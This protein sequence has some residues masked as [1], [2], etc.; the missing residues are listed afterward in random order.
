MAMNLANTD[1]PNP[2]IVRATC[3]QDVNDRRDVITRL[4]WHED[5]DLPEVRDIMEFQ[6]RFKATER[7]YK[8]AFKR[9][10]LQ[11]NAAGPDMKHMVRIRKRRLEEDGKDTQFSL[12]KRRVPGEKIDRWVQRTGFENRMTMSELPLMGKTPPNIDY[13]TPSEYNSLPG[14]P[15]D[16]EQDALVLASPHTHTAF[17]LG[18][19]AVLDLSGSP[20]P[21]TPRPMS[22]NSYPLS[23]GLSLLQSS[24]YDGEAIPP[25]MDEEQV[26][27]HR[28]N[29]SPFRLEFSLKEDH[30]DTI[31]SSV[32]LRMT[33]MSEQSFMGPT[34]SG[35]VQH[36]TLHSAPAL[37]PRHK[38]RPETQTQV[39]ESNFSGHEDGHGSSEANSSE[40]Q[41]EAYIR[42]SSPG[43]LDA[44]HSS[45]VHRLQPAEDDSLVVIDKALFEQSVL[46]SAMCRLAMESDGEMMGRYL[47]AAASRGDRV[48]VQEILASRHHCV[49]ALSPAGRTALSNAAFAGHCKIVKD[50]LSAGADMHVWLDHRG[51]DLGT[52]IKLAIEA[53]QVD[54]VDAI[55]SFLIEQRR[56][57]RLPLTHV[58]AVNYAMQ[59]ERLE[60]LKTLIRRLS[61]QKDLLWDSA[62]FFAVDGYHFEALRIFLAYKIRIDLQSMC[63]LRHTIRS[64]SPL[65]PDMLKFLLESGLDVDRRDEFE[66][67]PLLYALDQRPR[68]SE[69]VSLLLEAGAN[70]TAQD[71]RGTSPIHTAMVHNNIIALRVLLERGANPDLRRIHGK[72][73]IHE[74]VI[75][76]RCRSSVIIELL[77][78]RAD[79]NAQDREG[80]TPL[81]LAMGPWMMQYLQYLLDKG[82]DPNAQDKE[83]RTPLHLATNSSKIQFLLDKGGDPNAQD[84]EGRT[85][86]HLA[87]DPWKIQL[88]LNDY[89]KTSMHYAFENPE[90][91]IPSCEIV[92]VA[93]KQ[94]VSMLVGKG[95][96]LDVADHED[97]SPMHY[98]ALE[99]SLALVRYL[100]KRGANVDIASRGSITA[101]QI[102]RE[103]GWVEAIDDFERDR[104]LQSQT[105]EALVFDL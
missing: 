45:E 43:N 103:R 82:A 39:L 48:T 101:R 75:D 56:R 33:S 100:K 20:D 3:V 50:L 17:E 81:H 74:A 31:R 6:Y 59:K 72:A 21:T 4:Y 71:L 85:P 60:C 34:G 32:S 76:L 2:Q 7:Q 11:K 9:W 1:F 68:E 41:Q 42:I 12:C 36:R 99:N 15:Q 35:D 14:T 54:C 64:K 97:K 65:S 93:H 57:K 66:G 92:V 37:H 83:G 90:Y 47:R 84:K 51:E 44:L 18:E 104:M 98:A 55:I 96:S 89:G 53:N 94:P 79:P 69:H 52:A 87:T 46:N 86:L 80:R 77:N 22:P 24:F 49:S 61:L 23:S 67:T 5:R 58:S 30:I 63:L 62:V 16:E 40:I 91:G 19:M 8:G 78:N 29:E 102:L 70:L 26:Q 28:H 27:V 13:R 105:A 95:A 25:E 38:I 73:P 10:G 88:L